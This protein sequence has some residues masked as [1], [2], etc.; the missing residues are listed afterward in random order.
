V[1][2]IAAGEMHALAISQQALLGWGSNES[3]QLGGAA[4]KQLTPY[5]FWR[6]G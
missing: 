5:P 4:E 1:Q 3:G 6:N 2:A